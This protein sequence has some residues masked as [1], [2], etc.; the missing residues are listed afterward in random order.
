[1]TQMVE[2]A[3]AA[4]AYVTDVNR[5]RSNFAE[6]PN[7]VVVQGAVPEVLPRSLRRKSLFCTWI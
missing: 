7:A 2:R 1:M 5:A 4:G 3:R 6:W